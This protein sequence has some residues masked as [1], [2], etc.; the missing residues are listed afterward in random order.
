MTVYETIIVVLRVIDVLISLSSLVIA[1]LS[2]L[3]SRKK[4]N[5]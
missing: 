4:R 2:F 5:K 3:Y 1:L